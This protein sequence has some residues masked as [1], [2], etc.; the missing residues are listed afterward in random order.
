MLQLIKIPCRNPHEM[1]DF[2]CF[3]QVL[4]LW[5]IELWSVSSQFIAAS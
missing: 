2:A 1:C 5:D 3:G 4:D